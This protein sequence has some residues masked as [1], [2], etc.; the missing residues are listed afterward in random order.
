[1][2][3][4]NS[5]RRLKPI[6]N[7]IFC[8][9]KNP[10]SEEHILARW[11]FRA[12]NDININYVENREYTA[13]DG[14]GVL[15]QLIHVEMSDATIP[16][17]CDDCNNHWGSNLQDEVAGTLRPFITGGWH[18]LDDRQRM[19]VVKWFTSYLM[20][21]QM[22]ADG[23]DVFTKDHRLNFRKKWQIPDVL[24]IWM[25]PINSVS[26]DSIH[27]CIT[28]LR[29]FE[30]INRPDIFIALQNIGHVLFLAYGMNPVGNHGI[31]SITN[32]SIY[33]CLEHHNLV[34]LWLFNKE[35]MKR[36]PKRKPPF[37]LTNDVDY[38]C[39]H[40]T[41]AFSDMFCWMP[42]GKFR[43]DQKVLFPI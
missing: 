12:L 21:R 18:A 26:M 5:V 30:P 33:K 42:G 31:N 20:V 41:N 25:A 27:R 6:T 34:P 2:S 29:V 22:A 23:H 14:N 13:S 9:A 43:T 39:D 19:R 3:D 7:C 24:N 40:V 15:T 10:T 11:I 4:R 8:D 16:A 38:L 17:L 32:H 36:F 37:A 35:Y 1:M 28:D